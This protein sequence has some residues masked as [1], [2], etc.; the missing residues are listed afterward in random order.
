MTQAAGAPMGDVR[1]KTAFITGGANGIGLGIARALVR[2]GANV[3]IADI[4]EDAL[5][6]AK[7]DLAADAQVETV[8]LDVT[9]RAGFA[10]AADAA[11]ARFGKIH[12]LI[13]NAG[14]GV[15]GPVLDA[16]YDDWDWGMGVNLGGVING[17]VTILPR[18]K[19]HGE[20]GQIV[21]TSSQSA[22]IPISY[23]AIY[24]AAKAAVLG[25]SEAIRGELAA[26][27]IGVSAFMPGPVQSHIA[28]SGELRPAEYRSDSGYKQREEELEK[29]PVSPLWMSADEVGE[30]VLAGICDN[31]LYILTHPE[32]ADGMRTRFDAILASMPDEAIN[33]DRAKEIGFLLSNPVFD[34]QLARHKGKELAA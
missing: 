16:R 24:T 4:R 29:R 10:R 2:A 7:A 30:R 13:G 15:M 20:G 3:V 33:Q 21:T 12:M 31:D 25:I 17:L 26:E 1:G 9:D 32:F 18:I 34:D 28:H 14:I 23:S 19:A 11:E 8:Q 6:Q 5:A 22:L 27:N